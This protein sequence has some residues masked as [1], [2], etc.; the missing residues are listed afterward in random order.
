[1]LPALLI[2]GYF[3]KGVVKNSGA[4][5]GFG[6]AASADSVA[7]VGGSESMRRG[8][9]S[10][11]VEKSLRVRRCTSGLEMGLVMSLSAPPFHSNADSSPIMPL[12]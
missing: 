4:F 9:G 5:V 7:A 10:A 11:V 2:I 8:N 12:F 6:P 1:M 3:A